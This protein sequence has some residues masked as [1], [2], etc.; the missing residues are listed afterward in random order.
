MAGR[1]DERSKPVARLMQSGPT[2]RTSTTCW[3]D[4]T[5]SPFSALFETFE[6][7]RVILCALFKSVHQFG[8]ESTRGDNAW[9]PAIIQRLFF[10][11]VPV[12]FEFPD[13]FRFCCGNQE[14]QSCQDL[15]MSW[16][17]FRQDCAIHRSD[18][19]AVQVVINIQES[20]YVKLSDTITASCMEWD[21]KQVC[22]A[23]GRI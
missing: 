3:T 13:T 7:S 8:T 11:A 4:L 15:L 16:T 1:D 17:A 6:T 18:F 10:Q 19:L 9:H 20:Y 12:L 5:T 2:A 22:H 14:F 23:S 21:A